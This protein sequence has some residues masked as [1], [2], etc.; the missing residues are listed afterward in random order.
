MLSFLML[1]TA[2]TGYLEEEKPDNWHERCPEL[3]LNVFRKTKNPYA[4]ESLLKIMS[5]G[6]SDLS[7]AAWTIAL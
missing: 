3:H 4:K 7:W 5:V 6:L 1:I 2:R